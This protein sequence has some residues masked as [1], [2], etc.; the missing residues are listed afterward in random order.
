[1]EQIEFFLVT[2]WLPA[3]FGLQRWTQPD[4]N[5]WQQFKQPKY[6]PLG[7]AASEAGKCGKKV[8]E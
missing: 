5:E 7:F 2:G 6:E 3:F 1:M 8:F 4:L